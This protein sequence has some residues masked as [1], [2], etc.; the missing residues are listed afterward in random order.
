MTWWM[1]VL[2]PLVF[3]AMAMVDF[4]H[5]RYVQAVHDRDAELAARWSVVQWGSSIVGFVVAVK[6]SMWALPFEAAGLYY[7]TKWALRRVR[8]P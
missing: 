4:A 2:G 3:C 1:L 5:T 7:G 6:V 8:T